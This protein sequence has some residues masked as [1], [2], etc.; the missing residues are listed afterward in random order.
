MTDYEFLVLYSLALTTV[1]VPTTNRLMTG[2]K[3]LLENIA[4]KKF[5][6]A[7]LT[8]VS[9]LLDAFFKRSSTI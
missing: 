5:A 9:M 3:T 1:Q 2:W 8:L 4:C 6:T 7:H